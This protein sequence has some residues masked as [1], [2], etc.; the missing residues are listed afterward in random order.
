MCIRDS[1]NPEEKLIS[2]TETKLWKQRLSE[3]LAVLPPRE[4][5]II[6]SRFLSEKTPSRRD[7]GQKLG[8]SK[9]RIRQLE[10]RALARMRALLRPNE[11][12]KMKDEVDRYFI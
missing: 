11:A 10:L 6:K 1:P 8:V 9:E 12:Q 3:A 7:L 2:S 4:F 5:T